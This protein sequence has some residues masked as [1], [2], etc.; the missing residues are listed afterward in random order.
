MKGSN[1]DLTSTRREREREGWMEVLE[2]KTLRTEKKKKKKKV[3]NSKLCGVLDLRG[4]IRKKKSLKKGICV[5]L[6]VRWCVAGSEMVGSGLV[7][8]INGKSV[9]CSSHLT[10]GG[11]NL[12]FFE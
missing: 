12:F 5:W 10:W 3:L 2:V 6:G 4:E 8:I 1:G 7:I 9:S 11:L